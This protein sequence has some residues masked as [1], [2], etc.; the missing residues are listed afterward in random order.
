MA[1]PAPLGTVAS[2][3]STFQSS[4][5][6]FLVTDPRIKI[7]RVLVLFSLPLMA[8]DIY[9]LIQ[10][11]KVSCYH[12]ADDPLLQGFATLVPDILLLLV[13]SVQVKEHRLPHGDHRKRSNPHKIYTK[14]SF[15]NI[16][17]R[18]FLLI[19]TLA[20]PV[21]EIIS[22]N[23]IVQPVPNR[24]YGDGH[25][26]AYETIDGRHGYARVSPF[27]TQDLIPFLKVAR[28]RTSI[29]VAVCILMCI[30]L[31]HSVKSR[32]KKIKA[33]TR[34]RRVANNT[35]SS[36]PTLA[37]PSAPPTDIELSTLDRQV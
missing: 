20:W 22:T 31:V 30:E 13:Y 14:F 9:N 6:I 15:G 1:T 37:T 5:P 2:T 16:F 3:D 4:K 32:I 17:W 10:G 23:G 36:S 34:R 7:H 24:C 8:L 33:E 11:V 25:D 27:V 12:V 26:Q 29:C 21:R 28:V 19:L 18:F 35:K